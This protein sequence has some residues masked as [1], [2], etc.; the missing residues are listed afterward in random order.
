M[1]KV[2]KLIPSGSVT[3]CL[4]GGVDDSMGSM[5]VYVCMELGQGDHE[6]TIRVCHGAKLNR[7]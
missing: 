1:N 7:G 4:A 2:V 5:N 6:T 3:G